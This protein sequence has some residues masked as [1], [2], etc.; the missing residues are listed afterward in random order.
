M[1]KVISV[2]NQ[3]GGVAKSTTT[4]NLGVGLARQGK[5]V[6]LIDAD[7]QGSLTASLGYVEPDDIGTTLATI[8]M[9]IIN[10]EEIA[11]EEGILHHE[12]QLDLLPANIELSALEV[13][14]SNVM[15]REL[16]MKEYIDTM[17][18]RYDCILMS[19]FHN[20]SF[21]NT[22]LIAMQRPDATLVT[23]YRNWQSMGRQVK[24]GEK[25][26]TIIAPAPI[27]RKKEQTVL[28]QDQKPVIGSDGK[29]KMEEV[30]VTLPCFKAITV[31]DIEQTTGE[32]IQTLAP[33]IL[34]AAVED[35]D[36]FLEAIREISPVP[37]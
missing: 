36:L 13:T 5:K 7:P 25:G 8:M 37:I 26:I 31:F 11:E 20:Y 21:N 30:E 17:R 24:K 23:G 15:S 14:M 6:L 10:D 34:T 33:E 3:K 29:P 9:N 1:G 35:Y 2:A 4:L 19:K 32:S 22:L 12:E 27:K 28:D 16:I 18:S